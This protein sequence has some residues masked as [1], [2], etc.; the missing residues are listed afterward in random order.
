MIETAISQSAQ[1][2]KL[3]HDLRNA[4]AGVRAVVQI[5]RDRLPKNSESALLGQAM[6]RLDEVDGTLRRV[7]ASANTEAPL[8]YTI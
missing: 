3:A 4:L 6:V 8:D 1:A 2:S 7:L 5:V